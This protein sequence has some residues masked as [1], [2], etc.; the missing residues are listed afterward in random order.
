MGAALQEVVDRFVA[1]LHEQLG[2][3]LVSVVLFG[4]VARGDYRPD[5]DVDVLI[6][7]ERLP[8]PVGQRCDHVRPTKEAL[9]PLLAG[10]RKRGRYHDLAL[11][12]K[13]P[14]EAQPAAP[15]YLDMTADAVVWIRQPSIPC[16]LPA[17]HP[18]TGRSVRC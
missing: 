13:T 15:S 12:I 4:S 16:T 9:P 5:W 1:A 3:D 10:L 14:E 11:L 8:A 17:A 2:P 18:R 6:V 7:A